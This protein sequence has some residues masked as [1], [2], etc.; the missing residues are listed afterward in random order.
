MEIMQRGGLPR[1]RY[2]QER[3]EDRTFSGTLSEAEGAT[4][5]GLKE[6]KSQVRKPPY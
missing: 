6:R 1:F 5:Y 2:G 3:T 4:T